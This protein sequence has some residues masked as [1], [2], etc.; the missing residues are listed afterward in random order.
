MVKAWLAISEALKYSEDLDDLDICQ[1]L[2]HDIESRLAK[3][4]WHNDLQDAK[5]DVVAK[6]GEL[7]WRDTEE[8]TASKSLRKSAVMRINAP[9]S[10]ERCS[11]VNIRASS[12]QHPKSSSDTE[13]KASTLGLMATPGDS[14]CGLEKLNEAVGENRADDHLPIP[15]VPTSCPFDNSY[16]QGRQL[17]LKMSYCNG[18]SASA[19][20]RNLQ[21]GFPLHRGDFLWL[22][23]QFIL[24]EF[25][26]GGRIN[27]ADPSVFP[28]VG[29]VWPRISRFCNMST[30]SRHPFTDYL[31]T[32]AKRASEGTYSTMQ[33]VVSLKAA[34]EV[35]RTDIVK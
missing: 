10:K 2:I 6:N 28:D 25:P 8:A 11:K 5:N 27:C 13:S 18:S 14:W 21:K 19:A 7:R 15:T 35:L 24:Q 3:T 26:Q 33:A 1:K 12:V 23:D 30:F 31:H 17:I 16:Y 4:K 22:L 34:L 9:I 32:V 20:A 29:S